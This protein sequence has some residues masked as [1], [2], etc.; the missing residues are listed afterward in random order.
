VRLSYT[1]VDVFA[2]APFGGNPLCVFD[3]PDDLADVVMVRLTRELGHSETTFLQDG[4]RRLRIFV[5]SGTG[6]SEIRFA[7]HP[8]LGS[9]CVAAPAGGSVTFETGV[10]LIGVT[11]E[12]LGEGVWQARMQQPIPRMDW[13]AV[14]TEQ[15]AAALGLQAGALREDLPVEAVNNGMASV[16]VPLRR[17]VD[18]QQAR[19][20]MRRLAD[21]FGPD[22]SC[23]V[24][25]ALG[26]LAPDADVHC[27]VFG[28]FDLAPEDPATG[29]AN[30]PLGEYL[31]RHNVLPG[32]LVRAE[33]GHAIGRP[34]RLL[35]E[36]VRE[37]GMTV[38]VYVSGRVHL[39]GRGEFVLQ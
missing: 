30:G 26:G 34:S 19:P 18:V 31:V 21:L 8:I 28:P 23:V 10:G 1:W 9:A 7:G 35:T 14:G 16:L 6:G 29:S 38:A 20:D 27:R 5:P 4:G 17:L 36:V 15:L 25:F 24:L 37:Q 12:R 39:M 2:D 32:P 3:A 22:G 33:Q 13:T 11:V